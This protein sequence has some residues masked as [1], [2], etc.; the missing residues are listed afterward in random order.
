MELEQRIVKIQYEVFGKTFESENLPEQIV[1]KYSTFNTELTNSYANI[2]P[3][4]ASFGGELHIKKES[5]IK[6]FPPIH[7]LFEF[8]GEI[9]EKNTGEGEITLFQMN[10]DWPVPNQEII[11][12]QP[13]GEKMIKADTIINPSNA[14]PK[15]IIRATGRSIVWELLFPAMRVEEGKVIMSKNEKWSFRSQVEANFDENSLNA[16]LNIMLKED[17]RY[18]FIYE[19][20]VA[21]IWEAFIHATLSQN[22][23]PGQFIATPDLAAQFSLFSTG[24]IYHNLS[25]ES[26]ALETS[27]AFNELIEKN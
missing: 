26:A 3:E 15:T 18:A 7:K 1:Q 2:F 8:G 17:D 13:E 25:P 6:N 14:N 12:K 23:L 11:L 27:E 19:P 9:A 20:I 21:Q 5:E 10:V 4:Y 16:S 22:S 24:F